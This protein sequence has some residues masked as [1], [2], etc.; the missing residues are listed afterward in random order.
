MT[1]TEVMNLAL[2]A[3]DA[4]TDDIDGT[5]LNSKPSFDMALEAIAA[6][7]KALAQPAQEQG[8]ERSAEYWAGKYPVPL[9]YELVKKRATQQEPVAMRYDFDGYGYMYIDNGSGSDWQTRIKGAEPLYVLSQHKPPTDSEIIGV[10][11]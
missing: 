3:L 8:E 7:K 2:E 6:I 10:E 5:G 9:G 4:I 1:Q 11:Q